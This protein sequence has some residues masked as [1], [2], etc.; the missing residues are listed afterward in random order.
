MALVLRTG[1][2]APE[3][4]V[5][6]SLDDRGGHVAGGREAS[7]N[8]AEEPGVEALITQ[9]YRQRSYPQDAVAYEQ[10]VAAQRSF[11]ALPLRVSPRQAVRATSPLRVAGPWR[12]LGPAGEKA[13]VPGRVRHYATR[14]ETVSGRVT[15]L[16]A[17]PRCVPGACRLW[18]GAAGGGVFRTD[19]ALAARPVWKSTSNRLTSS[20]IGYL[21]RDPN[22]P[23]GRTLYVGTGE[24]NSSADSEAGVGVFK[25]VDG[26]DTWSLLAGSPAVA[27]GAAVSGIAVDPRNPRVLYVSTM[28]SLHGSSSVFGGAQVPPGAPRYGVYRSA[29]GGAS[30]T[31]LFSIGDGDSARP[32]NQIALDPSDPGTLYA[33]VVGEGLFRR[34]PRRDGD[35]RFH[36]IFRFTGGEAGDGSRVVFALA[37]LGSGL[38]I[39]VGSSNPDEEQGV[40]HLYR[41][42][43]GN[44]PAARLLNGWGWLSDT[45]PGTPGFT[46]YRYCQELCW[47]S[48]VVV[49]PPGRPN[50]VWLGGQ[51]D[52][53]EAWAG[54]TAGRAVLRSTDGGRSFSDL[55][56]DARRP[57]HQ[58][59]P[60][61]HVI[62][63]APNRQRV[64]FI[65]SDGGIVRMSGGFT[66]AAGRCPAWLGRSLRASCRRLHRRVPV[67]TTSLNAGLDTLQLQSASLSS[68]P[69]VPAIL[70]G[71]QDNGTWSYLPGAGWRN[72]AAGDGGQ[73]GIDAVDPRILFHTY[74]GAEVEINHSAGKPSAWRSISAPLVASKEHVSFY[75][76]IVND[77]RV[78]G[79]IFLGMQHVWRTK[80]SGGPRATIVSSCA[81]Y[82]APRVC[83][84]WVPL[85]ADLTSTAFG[86]DRRRTCELPR[87]PRSTTATSSPS[88]APRATRPRSGQRRSRAAC[89]YRRTSMALPQRSRSRASTSRRARLGG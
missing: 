28:H 69:Q 75:M 24:P 4:E 22:D 85:G 6:P 53:D 40:A 14:G 10:A 13:L 8:E 3:A 29:D 20:A 52:Y 67:R 36:R 27:A 41:T 63:F 81:A 59:H 1:G 43:R 38:R 17:A 60:D 47:Y 68:N 77:P 64:A 9:G 23:T 54:R 35:R 62:A 66:G 33:A 78:G 49:S 89:S 84:D 70:V 65:G 15:A 58:L 48:N 45:R 16:L 44:R 21:A 83:G 18:L 88:N 31:L 71:T 11:T 76:P 39:Y 87:K 30:F 5:A 82:P 25:S 73:S 32:V 2:D 86:D 55:T 12:S 34:S 74:Y 50:E 42:D 26:G 80:Q 57:A 19:D 79:T 61:I 72:T 46:S 7:D 56:S 37:D 51:F